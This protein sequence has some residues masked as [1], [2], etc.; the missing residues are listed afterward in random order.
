MAFQLGL[1]RDD[2][3][4]V[5]QGRLDMLKPTRSDE[6]LA[7]V[8]QY[9][10]RCKQELPRRFVDDSM[11][12]TLAPHVDWLALYRSEQPPSNTMKVHIRD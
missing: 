9:I 4:L 1:Q 12:E 2:R 5:R 11:F 8:R 6:I 3:P 10:E 7:S